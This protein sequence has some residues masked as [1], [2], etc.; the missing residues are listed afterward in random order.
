MGLIDMRLMT[1]L[2][3]SGS[4]ALVSASAAAQADPRTQAEQF[5]KEAEALMD[6]G[7]FKAACPKYEETVR[8][9]PQGI[10]AKERLA[11]CYESTNRPKTAFDM[12]WRAS[13]QAQEAGQ[14]ERGAT[15]K[16]NIQR[17]E[18]RLPR[19]R[20]DFGSLG[21]NGQFKIEEDGV[22]IPIAEA[23]TVRYVEVGSHRLRVSTAGFEPFET[24]F[25]ATEGAQLSLVIALKP[26]AAKKQAA[27]PQSAPDAGTESDVASSG[28]L[29]GVQ[30]AGIAIGSAGALMLGIGAGV[31]ADG[32]GSADDARTRFIDAEQGSTEKDAAR[33]E[34]DSAA[35][36]ATAGWVVLG[37]G[38]GVAVTGV[39]MAI[40]G[41]SSD[42][43][44]TAFEV[45]PVAGLGTLGIRA[46]WH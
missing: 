42:T 31:G 7:D 12:L 29:S 23:R 10:G 11:A 13:Q 34:Y 19:V 32:L 33:T 25:E 39:L 26:I 18:S 3:M 27:E 30:I 16:Q 36:R 5:F 9:Q 45:T 22:V 4:L 35:G 20:L 21:E 1:S 6:K 37:I 44:A 46:T 43:P 2:L 17:L 8:L 28:G 14:A 24:S 41:G 40:F 38:G 15:I